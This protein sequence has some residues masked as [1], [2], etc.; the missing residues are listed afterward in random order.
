MARTFKDIKIEGKT[1]FVLFDTGSIRSYVRREFASRI[2]WKTV[3]F[4]IGLGGRS[5]EVDAACV[6]NCAIE[7]LEF[8]IEAHP[9]EEIGMDEYGRTIDAII[10]ALGMEK[11][12]LIPNPKT[13]EID[14]T[15]LR[16]R[17]FIEFWESKL[18]GRI[19]KNFD[20]QNSPKGGSEV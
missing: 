3:P 5:F 2:R 18:V 6:L 11:W 10:G 7:G 20:L 17:E 14:V 4:R 13:G 16:K 19:S 15:A 1:G 9:V 8:D 12:G